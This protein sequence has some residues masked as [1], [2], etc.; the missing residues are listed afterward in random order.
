LSTPMYIDGSLITV[1]LMVSLAGFSFVWGRYLRKLGPRYQTMIDI[2][3]IVL[4]VLVVSGFASG[5]LFRLLAW[6]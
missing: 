1:V 2:I 6:H 3:A 5:L 4:S